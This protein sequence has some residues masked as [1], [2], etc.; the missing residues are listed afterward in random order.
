MEAAPPRCPQ[1]VFRIFMPPG[2]RS[3]SYTTGEKKGG[4]MD[5]GGNRGKMWHRASER[6]QSCREW[7]LISQPSSVASGDPG[8]P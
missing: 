2:G 8:I 5:K 4:Q 6:Q 1:G 3:L 7:T